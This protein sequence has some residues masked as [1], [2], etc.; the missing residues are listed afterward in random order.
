MIAVS[1]LERCAVFLRPQLESLV[2]TFRHTLGL[3][4][5]LGGVVEDAALLAAVAPRHHAVDA[6]EEELTVGGVR[7]ARVLQL[8]RRR[9]VYLASGRVRAFKLQHFL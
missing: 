7:V 3:V 2:V 9:V 8:T 1:D 4:A 6:R 5:L